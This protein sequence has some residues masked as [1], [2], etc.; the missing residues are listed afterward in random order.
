MKNISASAIAEM[1]KGTVIGDE[2]KVCIGVSGVKDASPEQI[3]FVGSKKYQHQLANTKA[4][5]VLINKERQN[6]HCLRKCRCG[7]RA[8]FGIFRSRPGGLCPRHPSRSSS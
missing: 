2:N 3:S 5:I 1:V 4:G 7:F 6:L 8:G